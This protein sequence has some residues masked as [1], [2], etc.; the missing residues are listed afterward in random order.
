MM[1]AIVKYAPGPES[2]ECREVPVP[3][4]PA[5]CLR[6]KTFAAAVCGT[7]LHILHDEYAHKVPVI[8]GHEHVGVVDAVGEGVEGFEKGDTAV[9][10]ARV[11]VCGNCEYCKE[12]LFLLCPEGRSIGVGS[13]GAM[14]EYVIVPADKSFRIQGAPQKEYA[15]FEPLG[16]CWRAVRAIAKPE[17]GKYALVSGPGFMGQM[18]VQILKRS[19]LTVILSG[20]P[21]DAARL[22]QA[23]KIGAD[24]TCTSPEEIQETLDRLGIEGVQYS[25]ECAGAKGSLAGCLRFTKKRGIITQVGLYNG[26][27]EVDVN[28]ML[29]KE[30]Q[31]RTSYGA[32]YASFGEMLEEHEKSPFILAPYISSEYPLEQCRQGFADAASPESYK[33]IFTP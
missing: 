32:D 29:Y 24:Y 20:M 12:G 21:A 6:L 4:V 3:E 5:G 2:V 33:V 13:D 14:A 10:L 11:W 30:I 25:F 19:G 17:A 28:G 27:I 7:D 1:R 26:P 9:S 18:T 8:L 23:K 22:A 15:L 16:C 31:L